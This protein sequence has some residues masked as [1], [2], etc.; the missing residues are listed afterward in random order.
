MY[1]YKVLKNEHIWHLLRWKYKIMLTKNIKWKNNWQKY[2]KAHFW[3]L[4]V[5]N[6]RQRKYF[7]KRWTGIKI[8]IA[9]RYLKLRK[10]R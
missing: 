1:S 7:T 5:R 3:H 10:I 9:Y 4:I 2:Q 8:I 6:H